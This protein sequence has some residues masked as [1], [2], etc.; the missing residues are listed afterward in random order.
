M[1]Q[2]AEMLLPY[3]CG[4]STTGE[5]A[6]AL[7]LKKIFPYAVPFILGTNFIE[8]DTRQPAGIVNGH[9]YFSA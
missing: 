8:N 1:K 4:A 5:F 7:P 6:A 2:H 9:T 3:P